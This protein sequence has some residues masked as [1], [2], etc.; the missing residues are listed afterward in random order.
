[1]RVIASVIVETDVT[2]NYAG[3][4]EMKEASQLNAR[5]EAIEAAIYA[6]AHHLAIEAPH[7]ARAVGPRVRMQAER[8]ADEAARRLFV[9]VARL[10]EC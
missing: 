10:L 8:E 9:S 5:L 1:L 4:T 3:A 7:I 2:P 6:M